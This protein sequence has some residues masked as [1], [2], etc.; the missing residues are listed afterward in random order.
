MVLTGFLK[1]PVELLREGEAVIARIV[2][3]GQSG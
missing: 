3:D 1:T 2:L